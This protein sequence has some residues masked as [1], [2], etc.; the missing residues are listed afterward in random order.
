M[1]CG[2]RARLISHGRTPNDYALLRESITWLAG[3]RII[4]VWLSGPRVVT[5]SFFRSPCIRVVWRFQFVARFL[6]KRS[7]S[8]WNRLYEL[9]ACVR[10]RRGALWV[11]SILAGGS[12]IQGSAVCTVSKRCQQK[13]DDGDHN[14]GDPFA[15]PY[16][17]SGA[18]MKI[19]PTRSVNRANTR[20]ARLL[21]AWL[22]A[23]FILCWHE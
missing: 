3:L 5:A 7:C 8:N 11:P 18:W 2:S 10:G 4:P 6:S 14:Y 22:V 15:D 23:S 12:L 21:I 16:G 20:S 19:Q 1:V 13:D 17:L 9:V